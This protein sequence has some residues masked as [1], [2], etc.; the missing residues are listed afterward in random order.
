MY[1]EI[2]LVLEEAKRLKVDKEFARKEDMD[3]YRRQVEASI[4]SED[5]SLAALQLG[6]LRDVRFLEL[7]WWRSS[8]PL[9]RICCVAGMVF[10]RV[11]NIQI[12]ETKDR[13]LGG[14]QRFQ[15]QE[16]KF[17]YS[18]IVFVFSN[19]DKFSAAIWGP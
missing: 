3:I 17:R 16:A 11:D 14:T 6:N 4:K 9:V 18:E 10:Q 8:D 13:L 2:D 15:E 7:T 12:Q 1:P 19:R 5:A